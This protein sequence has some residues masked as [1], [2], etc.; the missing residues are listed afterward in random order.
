MLC[1]T[2]NPGLLLGA[3]LLLAWPARFAICHE[4]E[5]LLFN[6]VVASELAGGQSAVPDHRL[7]AL[8]S[9]SQPRRHLFGGKQIHV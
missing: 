8:D 2:V 4:F 6:Y 9:D 7:H 1:S 5:I 3:A